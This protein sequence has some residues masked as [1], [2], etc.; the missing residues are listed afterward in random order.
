MSGPTFNLPVIITTAGVQPTTPATLLSQLLAYVSALQPGYTVLPAGLIEDISSTDVG[1]MVYMDTARVETL[2]S[3]VPTGANE[4]VLQQ[5]GAQA[6]ITMGLPTNTSV[7]V[8]FTGTVGFVIGPGFLVSDGS[9]TY[10]VVDGGV[11]GGGGSS[12]S[13]TAIAIDSGS[14]AVPPNTVT[15]LQ[16]SV[17]GSI[18]LSVTN[19]IAGIPGGASETAQSYRARVIQAGLASAQGMPSFIKTQVQQVAGV[20]P[21]LVAVQAT[22]GVGLKIL[23][24]G[25]DNYQVANAILQSVFDPAALIASSLNPSANVNVSINDYPDIYAIVF[26]NPVQTVVTLALTWNTTLANFTQAQAVATLAA[27]ALVSYINSIPVGAP[28]NQLELNDTFI[29]AVASILDENTISKMNW[30]V[31]MNA[32]PVSPTNTLYANLDVE[33]YF[34]IA[35]TAVTITQ[36]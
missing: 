2:N 15:T 27:P 24:G 36:G 34:Q 30:V 31:T 19:P 5:L 6:G 9:H 23:V 35:S 13:L 33:H 29:N 4:F 20:V 14:W 8:V 18:T 11:I 21:R 1:A 25:G 7:N 16:T 10:Q 28:I 22:L 32:T 26:V 12:P 17:P 3:L